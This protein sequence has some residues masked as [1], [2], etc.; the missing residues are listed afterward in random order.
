M[1]N[2]NVW[3]AI[4]AALVLLSAP[5]CSNDKTADP[6]A[7]ESPQAS[8]PWRFPAGFSVDRGA[9]SATLYTAIDGGRRLVDRDVAWSV[10]ANECVLYEAP[11]DG[12]GMVFAAAPGRSPIAVMES[13]YEA[14]WQTEQAQVR[15]YQLGYEGMERIVDV[16]TLNAY[17]VCEAAK[18]AGPLEDGW[19]AT[20]ARGAVKPES[21]KIRIDSRTRGGNTQLHIAAAVGDLPLVEVLLSAGLAADAPGERGVTP[22]MAASKW[23]ESTGVLKRLLQAGPYI[24]GTDDNGDTALMHAVRAHAIDQARMLLDAGAS[25][26]VRN[27]AGQSPSDL[28]AT[29]RMKELIAEAERAR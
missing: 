14:P 1:R 13:R 22:L 29:E 7:A 9:T 5:S 23:G 6:A 20:A 26:A 28:A 19:A 17:D 27:K 18:K 11:R 24:D 25:L 21:R 3:R 12:M 10:R 2:G 16:E 4:V 8:D 15:R